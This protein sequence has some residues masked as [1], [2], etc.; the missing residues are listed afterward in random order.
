MRIGIDVNCA[1]AVNV[2]ELHAEIIELLE[3]VGEGEAERVPLDDADDVGVWVSV[4]ET[5]IDPETV[6]VWN[7][8]VNVPLGV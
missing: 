1:E 4:L 8:G 7:L 2:A 3:C 6:A 5:R